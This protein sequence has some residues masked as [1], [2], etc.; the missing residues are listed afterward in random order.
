[1]HMHGAT[2]ERS[3]LVRIRQIHGESPISELA[4]T[5]LERVFFSNLESAKRLVQQEFPHHLVSKECG[6]LIVTTKDKAFQVAI[7]REVL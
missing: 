2:K 3:N 7:F 6:Q 1:M 4:R 5:R